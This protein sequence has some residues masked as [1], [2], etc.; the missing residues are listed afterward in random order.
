MTAAQAARS[1]AGVVW[2]AS[3]RTAAAWRVLRGRPAWLC[4]LCDGPADSEDVPLCRP[5]RA[6]VRGALIATRRAE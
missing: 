6:L 4:G 3:S 1:A 2:V 5:H